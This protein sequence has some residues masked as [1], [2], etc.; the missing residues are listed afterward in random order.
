VQIMQMLINEFSVT[1]F[2]PQIQLDCGHARAF[3]N[4][5]TVHLKSDTVHLKSALQIE[6]LTARTYL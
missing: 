4:T 3:L 1:N 2:P 6:G 5:D